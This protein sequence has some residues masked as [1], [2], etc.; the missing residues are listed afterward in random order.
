MEDNSTIKAGD[1]LMCISNEGYWSLGDMRTIMGL[2]EKSINMS[3]STTDWGSRSGFRWS[4]YKHFPC[5]VVP[6]EVID[7]A[8][9]TEK[10]LANN[11]VIMT[12]VAK[13]LKKA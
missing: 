5:D 3:G 11:K 7:F 13:R 8:I 4:N 6:Q 1:Q 10:V 12:K 2:T 9:V